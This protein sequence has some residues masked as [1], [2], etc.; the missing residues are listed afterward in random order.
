MMDMAAM[1]FSY[2]GDY[3]GAYRFFLE[4]F[5]A[6]VCRPDDQLP[7][8]MNH[9]K[10]LECEVVGEIAN[11]TLQHLNQRIC[12]PSLQAY[13]VKL[14]IEECKIMFKKQP[15]ECG[16]KP[17]EKNFSS[18]KLM[19][20]VTNK[21]N[22][23]CQRY[24]DNSR[25]A[26]LPPP[27]STPLP[28]T[29]SWAI[30]NKRRKMED[31]SV[32]LHDLHT[33]F[34][35][36]DEAVVNYYAVFDGHGGPEAAVYCASHLHQYLVESPFY[37]ADP[38]NALRD[39]FRT[40][41]SRF[42]ENH[43]DSNGGS[44]AVCALL[45]NRTLYVA[46]AGDS[47]AALIRE[48]TGIELT[49]PHK[50]QRADEKKRITDLGGQVI[51]Y[52]TWRV[53]GILSVSR[54]LG[55]AKHKPYVSDEPEIV[56]IELD[57]TEDALII[58]CDGFWE[59]ADES[60]AAA[61][62]Y[63]FISSRDC[64]YS[65]VSST[66]VGWARQNHS[67]DNISVIVVYLTPPS[68]I[69]AKPYAQP[70]PAQA[71]SMEPGHPQHEQPQQ[72]RPFDPLDFG[73][74][75]KPLP[76]TT[77]HQSNGND[78]DYR[79]FG[80]GLEPVNGKHRPKPPKYNMDEE[81]DD[82]DEDDE[83]NEE[84]DLGPETNVDAVDEA[85][86]EE[87]GKLDQAMGQSYSDEFFGKTPGTGFDG[88]AAHNRQNEL[89][90]ELDNAEDSEDSEGEWNYYRPGESNGRASGEIAPAQHPNK[91]PALVE[92]SDQCEEEKE[93]C[94]PKPFE[95]EE[96]EE[97]DSSSSNNE[98][99]NQLQ[100]A[101]ASAPEQELDAEDVTAEYDELHDNET[102]KQP[103][104]ELKD[105]DTDA[106]TTI[107]EEDLPFDQDQP[108]NPFEQSLH[109]KD[110]QQH[111]EDPLQPEEQRN[112]QP[113]ELDQHLEDREQPEK[114]V[115]Q[116]L[117]HEEPIA[118]RKKSEE[119]LLDSDE[120]MESH[121]NPDAAEFVPTAIPP[122]VKDTKNDLISGSP[123]K[124]PQSAL[125]DRLIPSEKEFH[126][127]I[128]HRPG[129]LDDSTK[130]D[131]SNGS[132]SPQKSANVNLF[133]THLD[134]KPLTA[135][136]INLFDVSEISSTK[137]E[138]GDESTF[139]LVSELQK[140]GHSNM[141]F[142]FTGSE[143]CEFDFTK[144][145][146]TTS[147]TPGDFKAAFEQ[148]PDLNK[149]H[150][151]KD[152]DLL[153][154][155]N[156]SFE[157]EKMDGEAEI[158]DLSKEN[159]EL[160]LQN[161]VPQ[162]EQNSEIFTAVVEQRESDNKDLFMNIRNIENDLI[163]PDASSLENIKTEPDLLAYDNSN[164]FGAKYEPN[165]ELNND[166][167]K[168]IDGL[169]KIEIKEESERCLFD[170]DSTLK[171]GDSEVQT[172]VH[173]VMHNPLELNFGPSSTEQKTIEPVLVSPIKEPEIMSSKFEEENLMSTSVEGFNQE[174][175]AEPKVESIL[176][177]DHMEV[178]HIA[179]PTSECV[180]PRLEDVNDKDVSESLQEFTG[181][182]KQLSAKKL[183]EKENLQQAQEPQ[184]LK[185]SL[186]DEQKD[187]EDVTPVPVDDVKLEETLVV[188]NEPSIVLNEPVESSLSSAAPVAETAAVVAVATA[189]VAS[190]IAAA[191]STT[192]TTT[193]KT[194]KP[195]V[196]SKIG[197]KSTTPTS[198]TKA[199]VTAK[200]GTSSTAAT[201]KP[202]VAP[203]TTTAK[204][205][206]GTAATKTASSTLSKT[207]APARPSTTTKPATTTTASKPALSARSKLSSVTS[208]IGSLPT[209]KK[210]TNGDVKSTGAKPA[211]TSRPAPKPSTTST[212]PKTGLVKSSTTTRTSSISATAPKAPRPASAVT[213]TKT[214]SSKVSSSVSS[215]TGASAATRPKTAPPSTLNS[216]KSKVG[217]NTAKSPVSDKQIKDT[218]NKQISSARSATSTVAKLRVSSVSSSNTTTTIT[219]RTS[220]APK[221]PAPNGVSLPA[222]KMT[223]KTVA[224][225]TITSKISSTM[226][227][228][229]TVT[230]TTTSTETKVVENG[231]TN[232]ES[233]D[234]LVQ[235]VKIDDICFAKDTPHNID[236]LISVKD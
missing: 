61:L 149:V 89:I 219:K 105:I 129:E 20:A 31:R 127:E 139:S 35:I 124:Q 188:M 10:V 133:G 189:T 202:N 88:D 13:L 217:A 42:T 78:V 37:P 111:F 143:R 174:P 191:K 64:N 103:Q 183:D 48:G 169:E 4:H 146:M 73:F 122:H 108:L 46:W 151:L 70:R 228:S 57:G 115:E 41:D 45:Y 19:Q 150:E 231:I 74:A 142:S 136:P 192:K 225:K 5:V 198:P 132:S 186:M 224:A 128:C 134:E 141:D 96:E 204:P 49:N 172:N 76:V 109:S 154:V 152:E 25:L 147:M 157:D 200:T 114:Q 118:Q 75:T 227:S 69:A 216:V 65:S 213:A 165:T 84:V 7:V 16:Y 112:Q 140:T 171:S 176:S 201:K 185:E 67:T 87:F 30:K 234:K 97:E 21:V 81:D 137:A 71:S 193:S 26:L 12:P 215:S 158:D 59:S 117:Q 130:S 92:K 120:D 182:E 207:S 230:S 102:N 55:D 229:N 218:A 119:E 50:P 44:T 40:T 14:V 91:D 126:E 161:F 38:E 206:A 79:L 203:R 168:V 153:D 82:E 58:A 56:K 180:T 60:I 170:N 214:T 167:E 209:D 63:N 179:Q 199:G 83:E 33:M 15:E 194:S 85:G 156:G 163:K 135:T 211:Q 62:F 34:S 236:V 221:S 8:S 205:A 6:N 93:S 43:S 23:I 39:A 159:I 3:L 24:L 94:S 99:N 11:I 232:T 110:Q 66:L 162:Q 121:L 86:P 195:G 107:P 95:E 51:H 22:E 235:N 212:A 47:Q 190:T 145:A 144:D 196:T 77:E 233:I 104:T 1:D 100:A 187:I 220:L 177:S 125:K 184:T 27:P 52:G 208:K 18:L 160:D 80:S 9:K 181:L 54:A 173:E 36:K 28:L 90:P 175:I 210:P 138:Y 2:D 166:I 222:K 148:E 131:Y 29:S 226:K 72:E 32:V 53:N 155:Q 197:S 17:Q 106:E 101:S 68:E 164:P 116:T 113:A 223:S 178:N 123:L 98:D